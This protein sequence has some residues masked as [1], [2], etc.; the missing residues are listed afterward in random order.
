MI[1]F[2][3]GP[4]A[5]GKTKVSVEL[6][7]E[8]NGEIIG[9]DSVQ[10][11]KDLVIGAASPT[12]EEMEGIPHHLIGTHDLKDEIS[13]GIYADLALDAINDIK[14]RGKVPIIVGGT[15]FYV[16]ALIN[17]LSP[18]PELNETARKDYNDSLELFS[19]E[20]LYTKLLETDPLWAERISSSND[21]QRIKR[22]LEVF[23]LTGKKLSQWNQS[24]R[25]KKYD[26]QH[27]SF[28][29]NVEREKL[30][31]KI[32]I[33]SEAIVKSGLVEEVRKVN[34]KGFNVLNCRPLNSIGYAQADLFL[35]GSITSED[36]LIMTI[37]Q[38]TRHL[39][40]RQMTWLRK[41]DYV[42][43]KD[44][45]GIIKCV[46]ETVQNRLQDVSKK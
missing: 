7:K 35:K 20:E 3:L 38:D 5:S 28:A 37:A 11:Y 12:V 15:N 44:V 25:I 18:V 6:A 39:A 42:I 10:I 4:T 22:G 31:E 2:I 24:E 19:T 8:I 43:W 33:R 40:K 21:R 16:D 30:Y 1:I 41:M 23:E 46:L 34:N 27:F 13:A 45:Y 9:A 29:I 36:D 26:G 32:N 17:G 14:S